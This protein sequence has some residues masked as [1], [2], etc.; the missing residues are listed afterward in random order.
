MTFPKTYVVL[1]FF[2]SSNSIFYVGNKVFVRLH[3]KVHQK[4][5]KYAKSNMYKYICFCKKVNQ[6]EKRAAY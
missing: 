1:D 2:S 6:K 4:L 5:K 3:Q